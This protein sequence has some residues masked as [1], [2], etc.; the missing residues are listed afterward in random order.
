[1]MVFSFFFK[2]KK[3]QAIGSGSGLSIKSVKN[4]LN[5]YFTH[6]KLNK[7]TENQNVLKYLQENTCS[8]VW[9]CQL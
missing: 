1:M 6:I 2:I 4:E 9:Y 7:S 3:H 8:I 5:T